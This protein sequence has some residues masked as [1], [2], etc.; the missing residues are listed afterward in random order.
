MEEEMATHSSILAWEIPWAEE[1]GGLQSKVSWKSRIWLMWLSTHPEFYHRLWLKPREGNGK[2]KKIRVRITEREVVGNCTKY[3]GIGSLRRKHVR[4]E[5]KGRKWPD[6]RGVSAGVWG[7]SCATF[8]QS[9][10]GRRG[11]LCFPK[12]SVSFSQPF[13]LSPSCI[14]NLFLSTGFYQY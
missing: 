2:K 8:G 12:G 6:N 13:V 9:N 11:R 4:W 1:P 5:I 7:R 14:L 10:G 3:C